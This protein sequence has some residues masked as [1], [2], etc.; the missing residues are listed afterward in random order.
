MTFDRALCTLHSLH[1]VSTRNSESEVP[2][3]TTVYPIFQ[4][5]WKKTTGKMQHLRSAN[6]ESEV[7]SKISKKTIDYDVFTKISYLVNTFVLPSINYFYFSQ[8]C[9]FNFL[10]FPFINQN[11]D[12]Y[13]VFV[14][15]N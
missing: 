6:S 8:K 3:T 10:V 2:H 1:L 7:R 11:R 4:V 15:L 13:F 9:E 12:L 5:Q 14:T